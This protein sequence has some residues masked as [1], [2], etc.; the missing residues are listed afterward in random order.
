MR[1][2]REGLRSA[3]FPA[4]HRSGI[5]V[6][7]ALPGGSVY[8]PSLQSKIRTDTRVSDGGETPR[9][10]MPRKPG[11]CMRWLRTLPTLTQPFQQL[12]QFRPSIPSRKLP[13]MSL[14]WL[15]LTSRRLLPWRRSRR[16]ATGRAANL[17]RRPGSTHWMARPGQAQAALPLRRRRS[18]P[19]PTLPAPDE[20]C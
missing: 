20:R 3:A 13:R 12:R 17:Q 8:R 5:Q 6:C 18:Q 1:D 11:E 9:E 14:A 19:M 15:A 16:A 4:A 7:T 2:L 10:H